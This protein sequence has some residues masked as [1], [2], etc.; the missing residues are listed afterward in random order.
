MA[1]CATDEATAQ[2]RATTKVVWR[3][4][5]CLARSLRRRQWIAIHVVQRKS[6]AQA[7]EL[8]NPGSCD[9]LDAPATLCTQPDIDAPLVLRDEHQR[10]P[11][12][13]HADAKVRSARFGSSAQSGSA[14]ASFAR[15]R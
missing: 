8:G 15:P 4:H 5:I 11:G 13:F 9:G 12:R 10:P 1:A 6:A 14:G 2:L 3:E 7:G